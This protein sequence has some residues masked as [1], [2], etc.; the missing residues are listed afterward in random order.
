MT[1]VMTPRD[2]HPGL[3]EDDPGGS[4]AGVVLIGLD[5]MPVPETRKEIR[6]S[7]HETEVWILH[8]VSWEPIMVPITSGEIYS[9]DMVLISEF[10]FSDVLEVGSRPWLPKGRIA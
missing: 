9:A 8:D 4:A 2:T 6:I 1:A 5:K 7:Q 10:H 3:D